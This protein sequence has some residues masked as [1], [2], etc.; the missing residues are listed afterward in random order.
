MPGVILVEKLTKVLACMRRLLFAILGMPNQETIL[1][2]VSAEPSQKRC[3]RSRESLSPTLYGLQ[4]SAIKKYEHSCTA[5]TGT[6]A[7]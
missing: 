6:A 1:N 4:N 7:T 2:F 3:V 5:S